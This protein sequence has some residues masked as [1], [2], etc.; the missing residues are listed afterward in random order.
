MSRASASIVLAI[1]VCLGGLV[2]GCAAPGDPTPRHPIV[3]A[4]VVTF[5][6]PT[7]SADGEALAERPSIEIY[8]AEPAA[9]ATVDHKSSWAPVYSIPPERVDAYIKNNRVEFRDPLTPANLTQTAGFPL[10][11]MVRTR[12]VKA[13]A[14]GDS[15]LIT[16]RIY[17]PPNAP[18]DVRTEVTETAIIIRWEGTAAPQGATFAGYHVYRARVEPGQP[19]AGPNTPATNSPSPE[20]LLGTAAS[21]EYRDLRFE[22]GQTY[23]YTVRAVAAFGP[24]QVESADSVPASVTPRDVFPPA[25]PVGLEAAI[26]PATPQGAAYI[27]LSWAI[28]AEPDLAGYRVYRGDREDATSQP[29][30]MELLPSPEFRDMSVVGGGRYFY[31]VTAVDRSGNESPMSNAVPVQIP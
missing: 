20:E 6:L 22:F 10:A 13:R 9:G 19:G 30:N 21:A 11:Y 23:V 27:E 14:S 24:D 15:N 2:V 7:R 17:P 4:P 31:R 28:S 5:T 12:A 25:T 16:L 3:P 1:A 8:R 26:V 18:A 29:M